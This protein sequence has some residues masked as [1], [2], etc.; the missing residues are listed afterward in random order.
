ML[1]SLT[2]RK[3]SQAGVRKVNFLVV[4]PGK[5][6]LN[7]RNIVFRKWKQSNVTGRQARK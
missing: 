5:H 2:L 6:V 4:K 1:H 3:M 7:A